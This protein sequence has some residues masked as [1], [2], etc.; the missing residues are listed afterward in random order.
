MLT[1]LKIKKVGRIRKFLNTGNF[2]LLQ[3][4]DAKQHSNNKSKHSAAAFFE[5][6]YEGLFYVQFF[7]C[8]ALIMQKKKALHSQ[9]IC[10]SKI[11]YH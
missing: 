11:I 8:I 4:T 9:F 3:V 5:F 6:Y 10:D 7:L 1:Y 2:S